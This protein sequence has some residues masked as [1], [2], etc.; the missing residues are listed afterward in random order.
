MKIE[1]HVY[2]GLTDQDSR[3]ISG[4]PLPG[5]VS[6]GLGRENLTLFLTVPPEPMYNIVLRIINKLTIH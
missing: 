6:V 5:Q 3:L 2:S 1:S 4:M